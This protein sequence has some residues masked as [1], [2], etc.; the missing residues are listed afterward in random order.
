MLL[1]MSVCLSVAG[2]CC[3]W[4]LSVRGHK[5]L[6]AEAVVRE[7]ERESMEYETKKNE[8]EWTA[9]LISLRSRVKVLELE[10]VEAK[11]T[12]RQMKIASVHKDAEIA[13]LTGTVDILT[14]TQIDLQAK[15]ERSSLHTG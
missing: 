6:E 1:L 3:C 5:M 12:M 10:A 14:R 4:Y 13:S 15:A 9:E 7:R 8:R 11:A 2:V